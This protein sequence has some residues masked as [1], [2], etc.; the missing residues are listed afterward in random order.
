M[1]VSPIRPLNLLK[2]QIQAYNCFD[3]LVLLTGSAGGGKSKLAAEKLHSYCKKYPGAMALALRKTRESMTNSTVLFLERDVIGDDDF[4]HHCPSKHRFE[5]ANGSMLAYGGMKDEDQREQIR[6]IG[7]AGGVDICWLEEANKFTE[8]DFQEVL[9]RMRGTAATWRQIILSTNPDA[10]THWIYKRL[11]QGGEA[12]VFYSSAADN[13]HN[14]DDYSDALNMLTGVLRSRLQGGKWVQA[15]GVIYDEF[16]ISKHVIDWYTPSKNWRRIRSIDF[17]FVHPFVCQW[18]AIDEDERMYLY[19]EIYCTQRIVEDHA[20]QIEELSARELIEATV[21]DH[22]A[23]DVATL[24][25]HGIPCI[26]AKKDVSPGIQEVQS[27]FRIQPDGRSRLF[28]MRGCLVETDSS[29][30]LHHSPTC[31]EDEIPTY[32]WQNKA[33]KEAPVKTND[34][35]MDAMRYA[36]MYLAQGVHVPLESIN[37]PASSRPLARASR[38]E[39]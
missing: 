9:G 6:S 27:R 29:L 23:E 13:P 26:P 15:E 25:R 22:D 20:K 17:G 10:P 3:F 18:W 7:Q 11:I 8:D 4:V 32:V 36:A 19:K 37:W 24:R 28:I 1:R 16:D 33:S 39:F 35:G 5:Y 2:W 34:H 30:A 12:T 38:M 14:A 31:T 21:V